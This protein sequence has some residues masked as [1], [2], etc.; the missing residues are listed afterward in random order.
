MSIGGSFA[1]DIDCVEDEMATERSLQQ[2]SA[3]RAKS[4]RT[5]SR[6][7][8][9]ALSLTL[10]CSECRRR[11]LGGSEITDYILIKSKYI[12]RLFK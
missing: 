11:I 10:W 9:C 3:G 6:R 4:W 1:I 12:L 2:S 5:S 7:R 8:T